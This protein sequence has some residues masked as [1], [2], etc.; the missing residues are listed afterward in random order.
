VIVHGVTASPPDELAA[1]SQLRLRTGVID[2]GRQRVIRPDGVVSLTT[3]ETELLAYLVARPGQ[4]VSRDEL[5]ERVWGYRSSNPTRAVDLAVRRLRAKVE[6]DPKV[7]VHVLSVHG[8]GYRFVPAD[9]TEDTAGTEGRSTN[10]IVPRT[11]I[12]GRDGPIAEVTA[13][14]TGGRRLLTLTGPP[15]SGKSRLALEVASRAMA[16]FPGGVWFVDLA[17]LTGM[18]ALRRAVAEVVGISPDEDLARS[19][20][21][22]SPH[23]TLLL[24]DTFE[25]LEGQAGSAVGAWLDQAPS[26]HLLVTSRERLHVRGEHVVE[27]AP[28]SVDDGVTLLR[29]R[30]SAVRADAQLADI[31]V[32]RQVVLKLDGLPLAI[33]LAASRAGALAPPQ[34]LDR[35]RRRFKLLRESRSDRVLRHRSLL[36]ALEWSWALLPAPER[37]ALSRL[38][39]LEGTFP[40]EAAEAL[41]AGDGPESPW[42]ADLLQAL[43]DKSLVA[44]AADPAPQIRFVLLNSVR[45]FAALRLEEG[46]DGAEAIA[47]YHRHYL[48]VG[49]KLA[50]GA[51][52]SGGAVRLAALAQERPHL[53]AIARSG[54]RPEQ[55]ARGVLACLPELSAH[56]A[57]GG[58]IRLIDGALAAGLEPELAAR[59]RAERAL[60]NS[61]LGRL[62]AANSD[63]ALAL[64]GAPDNDSVR[65]RALRALGRVR[66][67]QGRLAEARAAHQEE[68][69]IA[70]RMGARGQEGRARM[71]LADVF[72][73]AGRQAEARAELDRALR[74]ARRAGDA[75][76]EGHLLARLARERLLE[77]ATGDEWS[78][79]ASSARQVLRAFGDR[80]GEWRLCRDLGSTLI[81]VG[82][83]NQALVWLDEADVLA[84]S[85]DDLAGVAEIMAERG[86]V[87]RELG[88][89][90]DAARQLDDALAF[91]RRGAP[92]EGEPQGSERT[93]ASVVLR[94]LGVVR[95][96]QRQ[97]TEAEASL[98]GALTLAIEAGNARQQ[99]LGRLSLVGLLLERGR[100]DEAVALVDAQ[101]PVASAADEDGQFIGITSLVAAHTADAERARAGVDALRALPPVRA[102]AGERV[103]LLE[104]AVELVLARESDADRAV[105]VQAR[106]ALYRSTSTRADTAWMRRVLQQELAEYLA[107]AT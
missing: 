52:G 96:L 77:G 67:A 16:Q 47:A 56:R 94:R 19:L 44:I 32:L 83:A 35:L 73:S 31:E 80:R 10:V 28:L 88:Q 8:V 98:R 87:A 25:H 40:L 43:R 29:E 69:D 13:L 1:P 91:C 84:R 105:V 60:V 78:A 23:S 58:V 100:L 71:C 6:P 99:V 86:L 104:A 75:W 59:L 101:A 46:D 68:L 4:A 33:E 61:A 95:L 21:A 20:A 64:D 89:L 51:T 81:R 53:L 103:A 42:P 36:A 82:Q 76:T 14:L 55:R 34:L 18:D 27:V 107:G 37:R 15:G 7:P 97:W 26:L 38:S 57:A 17:G 90:D 24:L 11:S 106:D 2:L 93:L 70:L 63:A 85:L 92:A 102:D 65:V 3:R 72:A 12:V 41:L 54:A 45:E 49:E 62:A 39:V 30:V 66:M 74:V 5:L 79:L 50:R 9:D 48:Q 22:R